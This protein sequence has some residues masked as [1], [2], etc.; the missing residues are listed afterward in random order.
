MADLDNLIDSKISLISHQDVRYD[1]T[2]FS[3]NTSESSIVLKDVKCLG[4]ESRV[5]DE[6]KKV[7]ANAAI[8][9][10]VTFPGQEIKDL[11]VHESPDAAPAPQ[12]AR[13]QES[14][15][16]NKPQHSQHAPK[17]HVNENRN[18]NRQPNQNQRPQQQQHQQQAQKPA[19]HAPQQRREQ[20]PRQQQEPREPRTSNA[21]TGAHLLHLREKKAGD[22]TQSKPEDSTS[23]FDFEAGLN[24]FKKDEV[25]AKVA[26]EDSGMEAVK[27]VKY[28]KDDFFDSLSSDRQS[29]EEGQAAR[30]TA[31]QERSLNQDTFGAIALQGSGGYRR[32]NYGRGGGNNYNNSGRGGGYGRGRGGRGGHRSTGAAN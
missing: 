20:A 24:I 18:E 16:M 8:I 28:K 14:K 1:G 9:P 25:L 23:V 11:Y 29:R 22:G 12:A 2:L 21:G 5:T 7:P 32:N 6:S 17:S 26:N 4:T 31:S 19:A 10:F 15:P 27:E 30:M 3:I 13:K